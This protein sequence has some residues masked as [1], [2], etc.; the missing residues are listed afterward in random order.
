MSKLPFFWG[1][2]F[3]SLLCGGAALAQSFGP[4][5]VADCEVCHSFDGNSQRT[6][7][8][9]LNG[10]QDTYLVNRLTEF[11]DVTRGSSHATQMMWENAT[12]LNNDDVMTLADYF[13]RQLPTP[14]NGKG[15]LADAGRRIFYAGAG[16]DIP[17]CAGCHGQNGEGEGS[18]PR[19]AGQHGDYLFAQLQAFSMGIRVSRGPMNRHTWGMSSEQMQQVAA[20]LSNN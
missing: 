9:R 5:R 13:S 7:V 15:T 4:A 8:P 17:A 6:D 11:L 20:F 14:P 19:I 1:V 12:K 3:S 10:Q 16:R 18:V 2:I